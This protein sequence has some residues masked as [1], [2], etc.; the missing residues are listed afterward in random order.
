MTDP[1]HLII[2]DQPNLET[3][4]GV[5]PSLHPNCHHQI[6]FSRYNL[7]A[8]YPPYERLV[9]WDYNRAN[10]ESIIINLSCR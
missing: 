2:T 4:S 7:T 1:T 9:V 3:D 5:H 8:E 6:T 10:T